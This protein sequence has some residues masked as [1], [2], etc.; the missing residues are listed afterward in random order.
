MRL[1]L[2]AV[3]AL[4]FCGCIKV[5][6]KILFEAPGEGGKP[7]V[8]AI[9]QDGSGLEQLTRSEAIDGQPHWSPAGDQIVF[10]SNR[11]G[12]FDIYV[13][14]SDGS[15]VRPITDTP[16]IEADADWS[17]NGQWLAYQAVDDDERHIELLELRTGRTRR[18]TS[19]KGRRYR[20]DWSPDGSS[21]VFEVEAEDGRRD[22]YVASTV[23]GAFRRL[24]VNGG[25]PAWSPDGSNILFSRRNEGVFVIGL[26]GEPERRL[27]DAAAQPMWAPGG[28]QIGFLLRRSGSPQ[29]F[30]ANADGA[31]A[32]QVTTTV[33]IANHPD[34]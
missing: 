6:R 31:S 30:V 2:L 4:L 11:S 20:P 29:V 21:L 34:W 17:P 16:E 9:R 19:G 12:N 24:T 1:S 32:R 22:L 7:D 10:T 8:F 33:K 3:A 15:A 5:E 26:D 28:R 23:N 14:N 27:I 18:L 13:M 25:H